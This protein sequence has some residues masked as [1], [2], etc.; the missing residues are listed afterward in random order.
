MVLFS[1]VRPP[2]RQ[3]GYPKPMRRLLLW[4]TLDRVT[5]VAR[6]WLSPHAID[7][8]ERRL[9]SRLSY[10]SLSLRSG[11]RTRA[12]KYRTSMGQS[13]YLIANPENKYLGGSGDSDRLRDSIGGRSNCALC[14][15]HG[16]AARHIGASVWHRSAIPRLGGQARC[17]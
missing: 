1:A 9:R 16:F 3:R 10:T 4:G 7:C 15:R 6:G 2:L 13:S 14:E 11:R 12:A 5:G 17:P 8:N